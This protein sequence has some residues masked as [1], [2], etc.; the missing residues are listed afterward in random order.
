[1]RFALADNGTLVYQTPAPA[2]GAFALMWVDREG[3][4]EPLAAPVD[5][6]WGYPS[7][8]PDG[9]R[10][11]ADRWTADVGRDIYIWDFGRQDL[12]R[13][14]DDPG[15][16]AIPIWSADGKR[17]LLLL[18]PRR[19]RVR[20]LLACRRWD[21]DRRARAREP[22]LQSS[23]RYHPGWRAAKGDEIF[24]RGPNG[25]M[26]AAQVTLTP[27]FAISEVIELFSNP[28]RAEFRLGD[29]RHYDVSPDG[30]FLMTKAPERT[31]GDRLVVVTNWFEELKAKVPVR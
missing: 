14:T 6:W 29:T 26:M 18:E 20:P 9:T 23:E 16:D 28:S 21:R 10:V 30:R 1:M 25:S 11:A 17:V 7:I 8:S 4:Q 3:Q 13:L 24:F 2:E 19:C 15:M 27:T 31:R 12:S 22:D 5:S